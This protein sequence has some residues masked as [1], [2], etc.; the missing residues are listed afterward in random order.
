MSLSQPQNDRRRAV[1]VSRSP[2]ER[3]RIGAIFEQNG[4]SVVPAPD[5]AAA[6]Q[7][8]SVA[9]VDLVVIESPSLDG[10]QLSFCRRV[11]VASRAPILILSA[12][13][14]LIEHIVALE[15]GADDLLAGPV[16]DRLLIARVRALLRRTRPRPRSDG[17]METEGRWRL[18]R[19]MRTAIS[20][21]GRVAALSKADASAFDLFLSHPGVVFTSETGARALGLAGQAPGGFRTTVCRLRRK[22]SR[23]NDGEPLRTVRGSGYVYAGR[24]GPPSPSRPFR[25][26]S[27]PWPAMADV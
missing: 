27:P 25:Q 8:L 21:S 6:E 4:F 15:V 10:D 7:A 3:A 11:S 1:V 26:G 5:T 9:A 17:S 13:A 2:T 19:E 22:L 20:P 23:L 12:N 24:E 16:D 18:N 14:E